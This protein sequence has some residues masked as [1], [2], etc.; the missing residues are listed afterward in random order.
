MKEAMISRNR[1]GSVLSKVSV[2]GQDITP[3]LSRV[4]SLQTKVL[5]KQESALSSISQGS[6]GSGEKTNKVHKWE[7]NGKGEQRIES[8]S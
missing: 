8:K 6:G 7:Y 1:N 5:V 4:G 2:G 3:Q